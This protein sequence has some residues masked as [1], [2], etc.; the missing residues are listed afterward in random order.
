MVFWSKIEFLSTTPGP[1]FFYIMPI[2]EVKI[3]VASWVSRGRFF[4]SKIGLGDESGPDS[5]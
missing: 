4:K 1:D 2:F 5:R 3:G